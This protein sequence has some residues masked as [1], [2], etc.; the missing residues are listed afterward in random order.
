M[1]VKNEYDII[2]VGGGPAGSTA[3]Y[4]LAGSGYS[5]LILDKEKFPRDKLCGGLLTQKTIKLNERVFGESEPSLRKSGILNY[6]SK[7][8]EL[9]NRDKPLVSG[10]DDVL[11]YFVDRKVYDRHF[12]NLAVN[13]G[14]ELVEGEKAIACDFN[15]NEITASSGKKYNGRFIIGADGV[16]SILR[17]SFP[18]SHFN[19]RK[20]R[21]NLV[22]SIEVFIKREDLADSALKDL[23]KPLLFLSLIKYGY[24][25]AFPG[26]DRVVLGIGAHYKMNKGGL[27]KP[28]RDFLSFHGIDEECLSMKKSHCVPC[29]YYMTKPVYRDTVLTGDAGGYVD[30]LLGEGIFY[31]QRTGELAAWAIH[32]NITEGRP[33]DKVYKK[34]LWKYVLPEFFNARVARALAY[35]VSENIAHIPVKMAFGMMSGILHEVLQGTRSNRGFFKRTIHEAVTLNR[36]ALFLTRPAKREML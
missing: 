28:F 32:R 33:L 34:F 10:S 7:G 22:T 5:V 21:K 9:L 11:L 18:E 20:W 29:G 27:L 17:K 14:A 3:G 2:I 1:S 12:L 35:Y 24:A 6:T 23:D 31:A 25:W 16:N 13:A 36:L 26:S 4:I 30:P 15:K 19:R 8:Y